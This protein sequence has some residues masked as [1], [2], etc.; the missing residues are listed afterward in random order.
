MK[1]SKVR[2][3]HERLVTFSPQIVFFSQQTE[4]PNNASAQEKIFLFVLPCSHKQ[5]NSKHPSASA[6]RLSPST[7]GSAAGRDPASAPLPGTGGIPGGPSS[8]APAAAS[9]CQGKNKL[10]KINSQM[11]M[12]FTYRVPCGPLPGQRETTGARFIGFMKCVSGAIV[13]ET[14]YDNHQAFQKPCFVF[15]H[16]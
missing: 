15:I 5:A 7:A 8:S 2:C 12:H 9:R 1:S 16:I 4:K 10:K 13:R 11:F 3:G 6:V 14:L